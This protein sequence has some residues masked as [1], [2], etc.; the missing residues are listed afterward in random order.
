MERSE[1]EWKRES[2]RSKRL[3]IYAGWVRLV[4]WMKQRK[5]KFNFQR[6]ATNRRWKDGPN[7]CVYSTLTK[8][9]KPTMTRSRMQS[10]KT[11]STFVTTAT[12]VRRK[13]TTFDLP[14]NHSLDSIFITCNL[15]ACTTH[16]Y[17]PYTSFVVVGWFGFRF[18]LYGERWVRD[19]IELK[20]LIILKIL[21]SSENVWNRFQ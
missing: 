4:G 13:D 7:E 20:V 8:K 9:E 12:H 19:S 15:K 1:T 11:S 17:S 18:K 2:N 3:R 21:V 10:I 5:S 16:I 6:C 14:L